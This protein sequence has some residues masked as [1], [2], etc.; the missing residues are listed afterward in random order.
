MW[1]GTI[2]TTTTTTTMK[3]SAENISSSRSSF[4]AFWAKEPM[5]HTPRH[6]HSE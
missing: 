6:K 4:S 3:A 5:Q 2:A 1:N